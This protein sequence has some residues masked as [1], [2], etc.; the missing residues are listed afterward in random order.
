MIDLTQNFYKRTLIAVSVA[1]AVAA[2]SWAN[3]AAAII[4]E[5]TNTVKGRK[6]LV[7]DV[8]I[9]NL[10]ASRLNPAQGDQLQTTFTY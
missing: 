4:T 8:A 2:L 1:T 10:T 7:S 5:P 3:Y 9:I 6:P